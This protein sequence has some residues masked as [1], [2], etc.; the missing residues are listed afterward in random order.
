[1]L[2]FKHAV[3]VEVACLLQFK[4]RK[5]CVSFSTSITIGAGGCKERFYVI[6]TEKHGGN[7]SKK[8]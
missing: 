5:K 6:D 2:I 4:T 3:D 1:M 8:R 7:V